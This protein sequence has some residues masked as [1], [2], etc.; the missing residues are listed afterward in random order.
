M[1]LAV[2]PFF[3][4]INGWLKKQF[5]FASGKAE[6]YWFEFKRDSTQGCFAM[7]MRIKAASLITEET[8][9]AGPD[10]MVWPFPGVEFRSRARTSGGCC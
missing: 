5:S 4:S 3:H 9:I 2:F 8:D 1:M 6:L 7:C 10:S